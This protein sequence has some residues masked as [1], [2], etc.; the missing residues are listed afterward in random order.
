MSLDS[1]AAQAGGNSMDLPSRSTFAQ[2]EQRMMYMEAQCVEAQAALARKHLQ[3]EGIMKRAEV[4]HQ[5]G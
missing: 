2:M 4:G 1:A 5:W 3:I